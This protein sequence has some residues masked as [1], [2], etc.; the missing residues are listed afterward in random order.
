M[1]AGGSL[2]ADLQADAPRTMARRVVYADFVIAKIQR[3]EIV[4][5]VDGRLPVHFE[6]EHCTLLLHAVV[7]KQIVLME[8]Y[9]RVDRVLC[10]TDAGD[11]I[12]MR[13]RQEDVSDLEV[14]IADRREQTVD[15]IAG[16]DDDSFAGAFA[17]DDK[18]ILVER[19]LC[20]DFDNHSLQ[21][22]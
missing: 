21:S 14:V 16:I 12:D 22:Y 10:S 7:Q 9:R 2:L 1:R 3:V 6:A 4:E 13:V 15:F 11:V 18:S 5:H 8:V 20:A 17:A 19:R